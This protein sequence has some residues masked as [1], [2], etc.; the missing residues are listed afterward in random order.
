MHDALNIALC[1]SVKVTAG[2]LLGFWW[3]ASDYFTYKM[4]I[5]EWIR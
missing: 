2:N 4:E 5:I 3:I 1:L